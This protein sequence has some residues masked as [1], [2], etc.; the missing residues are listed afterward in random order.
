VY[1]K[2]FELYDLSEDDA[3]PKVSY[4]SLADQFGL[5]TTQVTNYLAAARRDFRKVVLEKLQELTATDE[6]FRTEARAL[7]GV[8]V[9]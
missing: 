3:E 8:E 9:N 2:L 7:L 4:A 1:F 6:E 5:D